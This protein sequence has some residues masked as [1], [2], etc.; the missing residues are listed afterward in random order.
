MR[1][2]SRL[3]VGAICA[4]LASAPA[5]A[6][7]T[8]DAPAASGRDPA[9]LGVVTTRAVA[10][11][12][13]PNTVSD[14]SVGVEVHA[15]DVPATS[16]MLADRSRA[17]LDYLRGEKAERLRTEQIMVD[18]ET[19]EV[20]GQP[21]RITGYTGHATV[22]FRTTPERM[23]VLLAGCLD[24][25]ANGLQQSGSSP[26]EEDVEKARGELA[27]E[28]GRAALA[29]ATE[30]AKAVGAHVVGVQ[31]IDVDPQEGGPIRPMM[32]RVARAAPSAPIPAEAGEADVAVRVL[33]KARIAPGS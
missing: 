31:Q 5:W 15:R 32:A 7:S 24:H 18:P 19:Q 29:Q 1:V 27:V 17:L 25:G 13:L 9:A 14:V 8:P 6:Q 20:R 22:S 2:T 11:R 3:L 30:V 23:P 28:A 10:H 21:D 33:L 12:R 16:A 26:R 4:A